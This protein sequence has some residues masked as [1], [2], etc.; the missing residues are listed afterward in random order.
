MRPD[1]DG[2]DS[3]FIRTHDPPVAARYNVFLPPGLYER[4]RFNGRLRGLGASAIIRLALLD[5]LER[6][7]RQSS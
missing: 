6:I 4:A 5:Y 7:E 2:V 1:G 3:D